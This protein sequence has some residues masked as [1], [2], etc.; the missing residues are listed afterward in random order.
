MAIYF[1]NA[2]EGVADN[3]VITLNTWMAN[4]SAGLT[5]SAWVKVPSFVRNNQTILCVAGS[6]STT[7]CI[8]FQLEAGGCIM[9]VNAG[10]NNAQSADIGRPNEW[11]HVCGTIVSITERSAFING[12]GKGTN[13]TSANC[14]STTA[15]RIGGNNNTG[16]SI[17]GLVAELTVWNT[18]LS[19]N[20]ILLLSKG[21]KS[22]QL[23]LGN[24]IYYAPFKIGD[25]SRVAYRASK[26]YNYTFTGGTQRPKLVADHPILIEKDFFRPIIG[27]LPATGLATRTFDANITQDSDTLSSTGSLDLTAQASITQES[28]TLSSVG[29]LSLNAISSITQD[30][31]TIS[32]TGS[33]SVNA[34]ASITQDSDTISSTFTI[35]N[36]LSINSDITQDSDSISSTGSLSVSGSASITQASD[37]LSSS[38]SLSLNAVAGI[39]QDSDTVSSTFTILGSLSFS[40]SITQADDTLASTASLSVSGAASTTQASDTISSTGSLSLAFQAS[41]TQD[42]DTLVSTLVN[43][44]FVEAL[45]KYNARAPMIATKAANGQMTAQYLTRARMIQTLQKESSIAL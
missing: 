15:G 9:R 26:S 31:D 36:G 25:G 5:C 35:S 3:S 13:T 32:S 22:T 14:T 6:G 19:D 45:E 2:T 24:I 21:I 12:G 29:S 16:S 4:G 20:E 27:Y 17:N 40:A 10:T 43:Y 37:T 39:T 11:I 28:D 8:R 18:P 41:I 1:N 23:R 44:V 7:N 33:L 30:S 42:S 34:Q 38:G